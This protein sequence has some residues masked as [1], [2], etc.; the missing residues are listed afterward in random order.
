MMQVLPSVIVPIFLLLPLYR[1]ASRVLRLQPI[2]R[3]PTSVTRV[4]AL[5]HDAFE[6]HPA[7]M[8]EHGR[9]VSLDMVVELYAGRFEQTR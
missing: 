9:T 5:P 8:G 7:S 4:F 3:P 2:A 1:C 6:A